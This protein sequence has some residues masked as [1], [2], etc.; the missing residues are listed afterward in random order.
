M[1]ER[2]RPWLVSSSLPPLARGES[3][4]PDT[5]SETVRMADFTAMMADQED[6]RPSEASPPDVVGAPR[7]FSASSVSVREDTGGLP[8]LELDDDEVEPGG[9]MFPGGEHPRAAAI[10][11]PVRGVA[12]WVPLLSAAIGMSLGSLALLIVLVALVVRNHSP[13]PFTGE[14]GPVPPPP[15]TAPLDPAP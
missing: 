13:Q 2:S 1:G 4:E 7:L 3:R 8:L 9:P 11:A 14:F 12:W 5:E 6:T 10:P 15:E